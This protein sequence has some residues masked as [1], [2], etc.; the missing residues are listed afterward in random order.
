MLQADL[1]AI[2]RDVAQRLTARQ[3]GLRLQVLEDRTFA[4]DATVW[5]Y[6]DVVEG[7]GKDS[8]DIIRLF[9]SVERETS[10]RFQVDVMILPEPPEFA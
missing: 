2:T 1:P 8:L 7:G 9:E 10:Q 6:V 4:S 3:N 5:V